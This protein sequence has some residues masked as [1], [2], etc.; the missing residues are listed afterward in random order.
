MQQSD[1]IALVGLMDDIKEA[2]G[3]TQETYSDFITAQK[4]L[5]KTVP[6]G[7]KG[8]TEE[9]FKTLYNNGIRYLA[10][11]SAV[12]VINYDD[13]WLRE[14]IL[15]LGDSEGDVWSRLTDNEKQY[16]NSMKG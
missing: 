7:Q 12:A 11:G 14:N 2:T 6:R 8:K 4:E 9:A 16:I 15:T 3:Y 13:Q 5:Y 1:G 10:E